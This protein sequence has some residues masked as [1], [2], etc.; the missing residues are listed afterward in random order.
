VVASSSS[1]TSPALTGCPSATR[2]SFTVAVSKGW[3]VLLRSLGTILPRAV[4]TMSMRPK[5]AQSTAITAKLDEQPHRRARRRRQRSLLQLQRRR[6]ELRFVRQ[7]HG[8]I[9]ALARAPGLS[10]NG[11]VASAEVDGGGQ[12][13]PH[14][15]P[16]AAAPCCS[17]CSL[18]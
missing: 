16:H 2:I 6:Q 3:M 5:T 17:R 12:P 1:S 15:P 9:E 10:E 4:A 18:A 7:A 13:R 11:G 14:R 8:R